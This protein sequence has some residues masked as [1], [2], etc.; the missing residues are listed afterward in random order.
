[1]QVPDDL[2]NSLHHGR[3]AEFV[4]YH[5]LSDEIG[6]IDPQY[7]MLRYICDR[8]ELNI[9]QRYW[10]AFLTGA[11]YCAPTVFYVYNEFPDFENVDVGRLE[12]WWFGRGREATIFQ[13]DRSWIR[14]RN[15]IIPMFESYRDIL[16][17]QTQEQAF[18]EVLQDTPGRTYDEAYKRFEHVKYFGR[19]G[20]F[21]WLEAVYVVTEFPMRPTTMPWKKSS[22]TSSRNGLCFALGYDDLLRKHGYG[23]D[24]ILDEDY[25]DIEDGFQ[26]T[27]MLLKELD[28]DARVDVW[29]VETILCA[30]KKW[31]LG[32]EIPSRKT[33]A[34]YRYPGYYLDRQHKEIAQLERNVT[35]GVD[36]S[37]L[38][39]F[40]D[41]TLDHAY[42]KEYGSDNV[43]WSNKA[44]HGRLELFDNQGI[45]I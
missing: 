14:S 33:T 22:S 3:L 8:Y 42:L 16:G 17:G 25:E 28:S 32:E 38:W 21:L 41:E 29:N 11:T 34:H 30:Y 6:D 5:R 12:R 24:P 37:V 40:R 43:T 18:Q 13:S 26:A 36:W 15:Q 39:D 4:I 19:M 31:R 27:V 20:M 9:E 44:M 7:P 35:D 1:M 10:L 45:I 23:E 2:M